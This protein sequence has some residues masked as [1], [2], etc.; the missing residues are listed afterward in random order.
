MCFS[1]EAS[2]TGG[3]IISA[4]G[5]T[6]VRKVHKPSQIVFASI[7]FIFGIQQI[8]EG[9]L[10]IGLQN[11]DYA[12][13]QKWSTYLFLFFAQILWP[14]ITPISVLLMEENKKR[15]QFI[16]ILLGMG[17][18]L[19]AYYAFCLICFR[20]SPQIIGYHIQYNTN[21][22]KSTSMIAV[23]VYMIVTITPFFISSIKKMHLF[24][25]C[26]FLSCLITTIF[27]TQYL[28]SVW[29]FFAA[30]ISGIIY[31]ILRDSKIAFNLEKLKALKSQIKIPFGK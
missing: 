19:S 8:T 6:T 7:P 29:C 31:W 10:W 17:I 2:F 16:K 11:P 27:F 13:S 24:G 22:P 15:K 25:I 23:F 30:L 18:L 5:I 14:I 1:P 9:F 20:V 21:F 28:T 4:I 26:I 3:V 12:F